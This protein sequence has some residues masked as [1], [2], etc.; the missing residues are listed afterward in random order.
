[1]HGMGV[2]NEPRASSGKFWRGCPDSGE[3]EDGLVTYRGMRLR[4]RDYS[5]TGEGGEAGD[6]K[7]AGRRQDD[8]AAGR[9]DWR[10]WTA[11]A[12]LG[13]SRGRWAVGS[14]RGLCRKGTMAFTPR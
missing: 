2:G 6:R 1:M 14:G 12:G 3:V 13:R 4:L 7:S 10:D 11:Q 9:H 5:G 8:S